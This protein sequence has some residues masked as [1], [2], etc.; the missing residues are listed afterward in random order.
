MELRPPPS[1]L[2]ICHSISTYKAPHICHEVPLTPYA[3]QAA[4]PEPYHRG[5]TVHDHVDPLVGANRLIIYARID[6]V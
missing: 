2:G 5:C 6:R 4:K 3:S 1:F